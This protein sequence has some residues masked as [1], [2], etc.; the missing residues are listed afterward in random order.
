MNNGKLGDVPAKVRDL[1]RDLQMMHAIMQGHA[2]TKVAATYG[3][4][5]RTCSRRVKDIASECMRQA[6][7]QTQGDPD[8]P[9][10]V[11]WTVEEFCADSRGCMIAMM[12]HH[13]EQLEGE[14]PGLRR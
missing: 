7:E 14:H 11:R 8:H 4:S 1:Y 10:A 3:V 5:P 13:M 12:K 9:A 2:Y 6:M